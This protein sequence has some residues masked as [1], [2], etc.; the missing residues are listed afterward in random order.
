[1]APNLMKRS[2]KP[3]IRCKK[4]PKHRQSPG[5]CSLC[6]REKLSQ[7]STSNSR[8][9]NISARTGSSCS[10]S[11]SSYYSSSSVSSCSSPMHGYRFTTSDQGKISLS[12]LLFGAKNNVLT[13]SRSL[14]FVP[15][16]RGKEGDDDKKLKKV[17]F[18]S[19]LLLRPRTNKKI[20]EG[21]VHSR[22]MREIRVAT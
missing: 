11:P 7:L 20:E 13:K 3:D 16:N 4:H 22:T 15:T 5:V 6:L 17:G 14:A 10:S 8:T 19:K 1:M 2:T 9:T 21:L 18:F 12:L